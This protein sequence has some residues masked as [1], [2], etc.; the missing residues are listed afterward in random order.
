MNIKYCKTMIILLVV[1]VTSTFAG[2][3]FAQIADTEATRSAVEKTSEVI[4]EA[5]SI[6]ADSRSQIAR[7]SLDKAIALQERALNQFEAHHNTFAYKY[8]MEARKEAWHAIALAR[9][10]AR[11]EEKLTNLSEHT[12]DKLLRLRERVTETGV[13]DERLFGLMSRSRD[14][15]E[16]SHMNANQLR[17]QLAMNLAENARK[18]AVRAE[19]RFRKVLD[20]KEMSERRLMLMERLLIRT[21]E[22]VDQNGTENDRVRM[23]QAVRSLERAKEMIAEGKYQAARLSIEKCER[24]LR[25]F[26]RQFP[27]G[28]NGIAENGLEEAYRLL[29]RAR[30]HFAD[31]SDPTGVV[32][33]SEAL[34]ERAR[35]EFAN[36]R[37]DEGKRLIIRVR[38][39]LREAVQSGG[40]E[41]EPGQAEKNIETAMQ[42]RDN[43]QAD[44]AECGAEGARNLF[45]RANRHLDNAV[46]FFEKER[47]GQADAEARIARNI[48]QRVREICAD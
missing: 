7:I 31:A 45:E 26:A 19:E 28:E 47:Y 48:Y 4:R 36:N 10:D 8:T 25:G 21:R 11:I 3:A 23:E 33:R 2:A 30:E 1:A 17:N 14:L 12:R 22:R 44:L 43:I 13:R 34:L 37:A 29:E 39:M 9:D 42:V 15:L 18:L 27:N 38:S 40:S 32:Q 41:I 35:K 16:E 46:G 6:I 24:I 20:L 5:Q